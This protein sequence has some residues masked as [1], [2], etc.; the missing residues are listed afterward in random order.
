MAELRK[1][2]PVLDWATD[3]DHFDAAFVADPVPVWDELRT[4]CPVAHSD[5]Y[6]GLAVLTRWHDVAATAQDTSTFS[7]RRVV[8]SEVP[9]SHPG[10]PLPPINDDPPLHTAKRRV[11]LP[12]FNPIATKRWEEPVREICRRALDAITARGGDEVDLAVDYAQVIPAELTAI[13]LGVRLEDV[14]QFRV[15]LHDLLEVGPTDTDV[16]RAASNNLLGYMRELLADRRANGG[17]DL[18]T[19]LI[20]QTIDGEPIGDD[21]LV[22]MLFLLLVA[23]IDTTW[24]S[25]GSALLHLARH[26]E[27]RHRLAADPALIPSAIEELLRVYPPVW[28]ARVATTD[29][30]ISGCPIAAGTGCCSACPPPTAIPRSTSSPTRCTSIASATCTPASGSACTAASARTSPAWRWWWRCRSGSPASPT[31]RCATPTG[32]RS[33]LGRS[34]A[35]AGCPPACSPNAERTDGRATRSAQVPL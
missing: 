28:V 23:G 26:P 6:G 30:E 20:D 27:D 7:S 5:R 21:E 33:Q 16:L 35:R 14:P 12:F 17:D 29:T 18:V 4:R 15:W 9:T 11:M 22:R 32:W 1:R 3:F 34:G 24:S 31:S 19:F 13:M 10:L 25:I 8:I 2:A